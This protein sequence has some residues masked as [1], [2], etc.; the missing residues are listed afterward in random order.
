MFR[1]ERGTQPEQLGAKMG[2]AVRMA[3]ELMEPFPDLLAGVAVGQPARR[4]VEQ[5]RAGP[6]FGAIRHYDRR[7]SESMTA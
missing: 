6:A 1:I 2:R 3:Q 4:L 7:T 5:Q